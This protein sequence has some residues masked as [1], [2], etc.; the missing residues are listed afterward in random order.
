[1]FRKI[2]ELKAPPGKFRIVGIDK[3]EPPGEGHF[4]VDDYDTAEE[5]LEIARKMTRDASKDSTSPSIATVYYVYNDKGQYLGG[6]I[7]NNE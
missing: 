5:A 6:D 7:Y 1:V 4:V 3:F 2:P